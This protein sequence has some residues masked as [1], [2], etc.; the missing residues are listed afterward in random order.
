TRGLGPARGSGV[1]VR[2]GG[3]YK[4]LQYNLA[5]TVPNERFASVKRL[6]AAPPAPGDKAPR[7]PTTAAAPEVA[8]ADPARVAKVA[9]LGPKLEA[10]VEREMAESH[11]PSLA[12]ALVVDG[13]IA[14]V[15]VRG[16]AD[17]KTHRKA[18][19]DTL[20]RV[21][22]ITKTFTATALLALRDDGR[23]GLDDRVDS[24]LPDFAKVTLAPSDARPITLRQLL[25]HTSGL[26]RLG[27][28]DYT[29]D[30]RD[31]PEAE[32]LAALDTRVA[33]PPGTE[34]LY[35]N[36]GFGIAGLVVARASGKPYRD[37]LRERIFAPLGMSSAT[38]DP[39]QSTIKEAA[40]TGY[41]T[42]DTETPASPWRLGASEGAGGLY[43][44]LDDMARWVALHEEAWPARDGDDAGPVKRATLREAHMAGAPAELSAERTPAGLKVSAESV[45][46]AWHVRRTCDYASVVEHGGAIDGFHAH[47][48]FAPDRGF[49]VVVLSNSLAA[50]TARVTDHILDLVAASDALRPRQRVFAH[51]ALVERWLAGLADTTQAT[52]ET[53]FSETFRDQIP[54]A[55]MRDVGS[56]LARRHGACKLAEPG[57]E[58]ADEQVTSRDEASLRATCA[59]GSLR[60]HA[61]ADGGVFG[62][63]R[64]ESA[65]LAPAPAVLRAA[66]QAAGLL[67]RWDDARAAGLFTSDTKVDRIRAALA[68]QSAESGKCSLGPGDGDGEDDARFPLRCERGVPMWL[69]VGLEKDGR[70]ST[71]LLTPRGGPRSTCR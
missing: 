60:L 59:R 40:A 62:G 15:V 41:A 66:Q 44:S 46:L 9:G 8:F 58:T 33:R 68:A 12:V 16:E 48:A 13:K 25:T 70:V 11:P 24:L 36:F 65:G 43:A 6:L 63:F 1:L 57:P 18:T 10:L 61:L 64:V 52:Y 26:P 71:L 22:S 27:G 32:V 5:I 38:F 69:S 47:V 35:S 30:D 31:V 53:T 54:L 28:F 4:I 56:K 20:Y 49:G 2:E 17:K 42:N 50:R 51:R 45:G 7:V 19:R 3:R 21:G 23:V 34:Y 29:R 37:F 14:H 55:A 39:V 67:A